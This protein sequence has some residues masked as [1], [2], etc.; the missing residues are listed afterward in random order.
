MLGWNDGYPDFAE[1]ERGNAI[2]NG[3]KTMGM[4]LAYSDSFAQCQV[5]KA[6]QTVCFRD[7]DD[8]SA[9]RTT[10]S[11]ITTDFKNGGYLMKQVFRDVAAACKGD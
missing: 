1:D 7:P 11:T 5:K 4:E 9:D 8:S 2:G 6:F 10:V 3:A